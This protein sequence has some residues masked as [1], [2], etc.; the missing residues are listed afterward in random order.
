MLLARLDGN[1]GYQGVEEFQFPEAFWVLA[2]VSSLW[3][4]NDL[5]CLLS[6]S[7]L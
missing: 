1:G 6:L 7:G 5:K 3:F 4:Q 2:Y